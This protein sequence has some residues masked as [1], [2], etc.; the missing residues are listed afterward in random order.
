VRAYLVPLAIAYAVWSLKHSSSFMM[1]PKNLQEHW[2]L[3]WWPWMVTTGHG[4]G[5]VFPLLFGSGFLIRVRQSSTIFSNS[6]S[7][8]YLSSQRSAPF[9]FS[10]RCF[11]F[12]LTSLKESL[13]AVKA[14]LFMKPRPIM[15]FSPLARPIRSAL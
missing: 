5:L 12:A 3:I 9:S 2:G 1:M 8:S 11:S 13:L 4:I 6:N 15:S 7:A 10:I 14:V